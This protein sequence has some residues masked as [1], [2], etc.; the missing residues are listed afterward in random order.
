M[1]KSVEYIVSDSNCYLSIPDIKFKDSYISLVNEF[2]QN[3]EELIP[4]P[5]KFNYENFPLL[6]EKLLQASS[7]LGV[8]EG[9]IEN[10]TYWLI[11]DCEQVVGVSNLRHRL[12]DKLRIHGGHI[13]YGIRPSMRSQ[14]FGSSI[15]KLTLDKARQMGITRALITCR[16]DNVASATVIKNNGG[17]FDSEDYVKEYS[18]ML[19]RYWIEL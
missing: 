2:R 14:G 15:L 4:F 6:V 10:S 7:G 11:N 13:G 19:Q 5:L 17:V 16:A 9:F 3:N 8:P 1:F 12:N 18:E